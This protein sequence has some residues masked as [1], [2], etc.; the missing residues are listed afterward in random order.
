MPLP[1][2]GSATPGLLLRTGGATDAPAPHGE[3]GSHLP[4]TRSA[5][6]V[7]FL[8]FQTRRSWIYY[9]LPEED[10]MSPP[11]P[12]H[13]NSLLHHITRLYTSQ[14]G[15]TAWLGLCRLMPAGQRKS[16]RPQ[17]Q[18]PTQN[19]ARDHYLHGGAH[20]RWVGPTCPTPLVSLL[21][22]DY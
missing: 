1:R 13:T 18:L 10:Q 16:P 22:S 3:H 5:I 6:E 14:R 17:P 12:T 2:M 20:R 8:S 11:P 7:L 9:Y 15:H 4:R 21:D 19:K